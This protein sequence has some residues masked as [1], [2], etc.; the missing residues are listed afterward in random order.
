MNFSK[1]KQY[2]KNPFFKI[3][4]FLLK[5]INNINVTLK[6]MSFFRVFIHFIRLSNLNSIFLV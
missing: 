1:L 2:K 4:A 3:N 6:I 5:N